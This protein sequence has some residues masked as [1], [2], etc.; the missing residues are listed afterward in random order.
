MTEGTEQEAA[1]AEEAGAPKPEVGEEAAVSEG[2]PE[3]VETTAPE[4]A[5]ADDIAAA[6]AEAD[7]RVAQEPGLD[8]IAPGTV[9]GEPATTAAAAVAATGATD[10]MPAPVAGA[11]ASAKEPAAV[12]IWPFVAY[13]VLWLAFAGV[14]VWQMLEL[15]KGVAAFD[16]GLYGFAIIG[17]ITLTAAG[18]LLIVAVWLSSI[19]KT[20]ASSG[21]VFVAALIR[22]AIATLLGVTVWWVALIVIDQL[23][24]GRLF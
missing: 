6:V 5:A 19:G 22:G 20:G 4:A 24:L 21:S 17:G 1:P 12:S 11:Q 18:P 14:L 13:D 9:A 7:D 10:G 16:S 23:R 2:D 8:D 15:P 3:A